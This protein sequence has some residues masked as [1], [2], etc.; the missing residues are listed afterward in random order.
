MHPITK[1]RPDAEDPA[2]AKKLWE[3]SE[4]IVKVA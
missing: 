2:T 3:V 4:Q 1:P